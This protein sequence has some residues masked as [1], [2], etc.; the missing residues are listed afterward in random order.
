M[1]KNGLR[2]F[3]V[4]TIAE[5]CFK[6]CLSGILGGGQVASVKQLATKNWVIYIKLDKNKFFVIGRFIRISTFMGFNPP[7]KGIDLGYP[8]LCTKRAYCLGVSYVIILDSS[9][10]QLY[11]F[12]KVFLFWAAIPP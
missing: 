8:H 1:Q 7:D 2:V 6:T 5:M 4:K 10:L 12:Y 11:G 3:R 9:H